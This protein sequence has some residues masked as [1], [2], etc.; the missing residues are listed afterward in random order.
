[1]WLVT[2]DCFRRECASF[3]HRWRTEIERRGLPALPFSFLGERPSVAEE[4]REFYSECQ[5]F[6]CR[7]GL[8]G[9]VTWDL[10]R[11]MRAEL[12]D[13]ALYPLSSVSS[14]GV[15]LFVPWHLLRDRSL[16]LHQLADH[17]RVLDAPKHLTSWLDKESKDWGH[18]RFATMLRLYVYL[19]LA[20]KRRYGDRLK[21]RTG[22]I[23]EALTLYLFGRN[24]DVD[25]VRKIRLFMRSRLNAAAE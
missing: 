14:A 10:P 7:W 17:R 6:H 16:D 21:G 15:T 2:D 3:C 8:D 18:E 9:L 24:A 4:D 12:T 22:K 23:D 5:Q 11:P 1:G 25:S 19:D 13:P 20:L